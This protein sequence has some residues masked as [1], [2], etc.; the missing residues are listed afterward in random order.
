MET[1]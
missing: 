1:W